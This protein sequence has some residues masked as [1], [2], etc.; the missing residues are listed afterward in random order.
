MNYNRREAIDYYINAIA[1]GNMEFQDVRK[2]MESKG[3]DKKEISIVVNQV[4][5]RVQGMA[6]KKANQGKGSEIFYVGIFIFLL[7]LAMTVLTYA[8]VANLGNK[9]LIAW[10][11]MTVG[12]MIAFTGRSRM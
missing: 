9:F 10:G 12:I 8:G 1:N 7:G 11:P 4:D 5:R 2:D 6:I 3:I